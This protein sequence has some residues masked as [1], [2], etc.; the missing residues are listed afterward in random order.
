MPPQ[1]Y[2]L[3]ALFLACSVA[4]GILAVRLVARA[5]G[6]RGWPAY[7]LPVIAGFLAFYLV[8]HRFGIV[9]G[10]EISL[11][12]FQVAIVGDIVIGF[13]SALAVALAQALVI[14]LRAAGRRSRGARTG[15]GQPA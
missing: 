15:G 10:P 12:G 9:L 4:V 11:F 13:A 7:P 1:A 6:P 14:R 2:A 8:G 5:D 3:V